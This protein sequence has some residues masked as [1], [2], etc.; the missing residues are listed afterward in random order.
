MLLNLKFLLRATGCCE[1]FA[2]HPLF[3]S[4]IT[5]GGSAAD[6][7]WNWGKG[8]AAPVRSWA[9]SLNVHAGLST[10]VWF[11]TSEASVASIICSFLWSS[12]RLSLVLLTCDTETKAW[13]VL[14]CILSP[15]VRWFIHD[16]FVTLALMDTRFQSFTSMTLWCMLK[17]QTLESSSFSSGA[18][19]SRTL[20]E[21][22]KW[23]SPALRLM[24]SCSYL[25][26][27]YLIT[28][29]YTL[30]TWVVFFCPVVKTRTSNFDLFN[31]KLDRPTL[32]LQEKTKKKKI[33]LQP[34][35]ANQTNECADDG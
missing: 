35:A 5:E 11:I 20:I 10:H 26:S 1:P 34:R 32:A 12:T 14:C 15:W 8:D 22:L 23:K 33:P 16:V 28:Q 19:F 29:L 9:S 17:F 27:L 3:I 18:S 7:R 31:K 21:R 2:R 30:D 13:G 6:L 24:F 25:Y 4:W